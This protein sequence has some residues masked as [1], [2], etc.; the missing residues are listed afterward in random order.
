M[1]NDFNQQIIEEFRA[2]DGRVA[3]PFEGAALLLL[4]TTGARSGRPHT[5]PLGYLPDGDDRVLVIASAGGSPRNPAWYHNLLAHP[6]VT[7]ETGTATY[8]AQAAPLDGPDRD[9]AFA[10]AVANDPGWAAY[11]ARAGRVIPVVALRR[12]DR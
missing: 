1:P 4:T 3:G 8:E 6:R 10:R 12:I 2:N 9:R 11:E 5:T 7:V